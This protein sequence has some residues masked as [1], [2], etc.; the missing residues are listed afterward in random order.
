[1]IHSAFYKFVA[2]ENPAA[3][4]VWLTNIS[5][6]LTGSILVSSEGINGTVA[7]APQALEAFEQALHQNAQFSHMPFKHSACTTAPFARMKVQIKPEIVQMGVAQVDAVNHQARQLSPT[8][9]RELLEQDDVVVI[10]NR[11]SFEFRLGRFKGAIDPGVSH[12]RDFPAF[13]E[14]NLPTW[15][16][17]NKRI[18]MYCTG[19]IRCEKTSAWLGQRNIPV[20]ELEG[21]ILNYFQALPDASKEFEGECFVFDNRIALNTQLQETG[22]TVEQVYAAQTDGAWRIARAKRLFDA[23]VPAPQVIAAKLVSPSKVVTP[24]G[25]WPN[26]LAFLCEYFA[27]I[28]PEQWQARMREGRVLDAKGRALPLSSPFIAH[29]TLQY[30][31]EPTAERPIPFE[32]QVLFENECIL[33]ADKPHFLPVIPSGEYLQETLLMRLRNTY[34]NQE[35]SPAHRIDRDTAGLVLFTKQR[36]VRGTYQNLFAQRAVHKVYEAVAGINPALKFPLTRE[37]FLTR[38]EHFMQAQETFDTPANA[39]THIRQLEIKGQYAR[40]ELAPISGQRHQLR[41]HMCALGI[42]IL[43]DQIYPTLTPEVANSDSA[44]AERYAA[45]LQ[46][47]ARELRFTDPL[48]G[49]EMHFASR[50]SLM[51]LP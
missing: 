32:A 35:L 26:L 30:F 44:W 39:T 36:K 34:A 46:L 21:G 41:V 20:L 48:S 42:P 13:I 16:A 37:S 51:Q 3:V 6:E 40:Y 49:E 27:H 33:V 25:Q 7:G 1:M 18:A 8:Q 28:S 12:F 43:N 38:S 50:L 4:V 19:G 2:L 24:A 22:T 14:A 23:A 15:Q 47:L 9:W 10:D 11:N 17:Q 5:Q 31:R 29:Q 45:P